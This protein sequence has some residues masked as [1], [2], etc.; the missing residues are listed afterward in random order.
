MKGS[1]LFSSVKRCRGFIL[2]R[3]RAFLNCLTRKL[4]FSNVRYEQIYWKAN[5]EDNSW[6]FVSVTKSFLS[7]WG[8]WLNSTS[9]FRETLISR[10]TVKFKLLYWSNSNLEFSAT[11]GSS[12]NCLFMKSMNSIEHWWDRFIILRCSL[13]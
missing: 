4:G 2:I 11:F 1:N 6:F 7:K 12:D 5:S 8:C 3:L 9:Y 13:Y 10:E